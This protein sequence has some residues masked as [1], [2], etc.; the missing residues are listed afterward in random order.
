MKRVLAFALFG[1]VTLTGSAA[2]AKPLREPILG[3]MLLCFK[4]ST[5]ELADDER[6]T[7]FSAS[8]ESMSLTIEGPAGVIEIAESE[9]WAEPKR[10]GRL[11]LEHNGTAVF[12]EKT[13]QRY[14]IYGQTSYSPNRPQKVISLSGNALLGTIEDRSIYNRFVVRDPKDA[15]CGHGFSYGWFFGD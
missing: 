9:V 15:A 10:R 6:V 11:L 2:C 8:A 3:P 5:F 12:R 14:S 13:G 7:K 1:L 4:Y